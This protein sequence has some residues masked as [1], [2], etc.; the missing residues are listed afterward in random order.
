MLIVLSSCA[1]KSATTLDNEKFIEIYARLLIIYEMEI[2]KDH[3]DRLIDELFREYNTTSDQ[4]DST[5]VYLNNN[6][7]EWVATLD[8]VRKKI[9]EL[10]K[11]LVPEE[12]IPENIP[13]KK[14]S[15]LKEPSKRWKKEEPSKAKRERKQQEKL[16]ATSKKQVIE[17]EE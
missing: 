6:P 2:N 10:R 16:N 8:N 1:E 14:Q 4:I 7:E 3:H 12:S 13:R 15:V 9:Q 11:E 17:K 5:L